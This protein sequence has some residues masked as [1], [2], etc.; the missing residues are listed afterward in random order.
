MILLKEERSF[1]RIKKIQESIFTSPAGGIVKD[2]SRG[3]KRKFLSIEI[4]IAENE[5]AELFE[6]QTNS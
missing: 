1:L 5:E 3:D 4:E 6:Y 2:I